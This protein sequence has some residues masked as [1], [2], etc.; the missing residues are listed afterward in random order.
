MVAMT[1]PCP[2]DVL[3]RYCDLRIK[4]LH[5]LRDPRSAHPATLAQLRKDGLLM[6]DNHNLTIAGS[7]A[8]RNAQVLERSGSS[9]GVEARIEIPHWT[10]LKHLGPPLRSVH[11]KLL[12]LLYQHPGHAYRWLC[13]LFGKEVVEYLKQAG[14][15]AGW[16]DRGSQWRL[17]AK[18]LELVRSWEAR[19]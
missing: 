4:D 6:P 13:R 1:N 7:E 16:S 9:E 3:L 10:I 19:A 5:A 14:L 18:G 8:L 11:A 17:T 12:R 2:E 15:V